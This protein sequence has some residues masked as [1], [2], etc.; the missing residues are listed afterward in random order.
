MKPMKPW[1]HQL[2]KQFL[3]SNRWHQLS[4]GLRLLW[5]FWILPLRGQKTE[6]M[7]PP[8]QLQ[9][10]VMQQQTCQTRGRMGHGRRR[11]KQGRC[12]QDPFKARLCLELWRVCNGGKNKHNG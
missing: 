1:R 8:A 5:A 9:T 12:R 6:A 3:L 10:T 2:E 7:L 4:R 11:T